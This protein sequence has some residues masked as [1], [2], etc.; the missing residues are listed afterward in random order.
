LPDRLPFE[1][2]RR[3]PSDDDRPFAFDDDRLPERV[4][5][6]RAISSHLLARIRRASSA[7]VPA[8]PRSKAP[9]S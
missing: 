1:L 3:V 6:A 8:P 2:D 9:C 5:R 4:D 7:G